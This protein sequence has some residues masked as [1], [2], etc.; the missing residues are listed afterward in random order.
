MKTITLAEL[1]QNLAVG[2]PDPNSE[3]FISEYSLKPWKFKDDK[4]L[5]EKRENAIFAPEFA[6]T[7]VGHF[8]KTLAGNP[9]GEMK[10]T[11]KRLTLS[12]MKFGDVLTVYFGIRI[13]SKGKMFRPMIPCPNCSTPKKPFKFRDNVDLSTTDVVVYETQKDLT[14]EFKFDESYDETL[15][16]G[17]NTVNA[18]FD[19][20]VVQPPKWNDIEK[21]TSEE[22][23]NSAILRE[24]LL[25]S[26]IKF[27]GEFDESETRAIL[28]KGILDE[29]TKKD[30]D[31]LEEFIGDVSPGPDMTIQTRCPRCKT[32]F[33]R[34]LDWS[35]DNF[36]S[37]S[38]KSGSGNKS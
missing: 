22:F 27:L 18:Q 30:I 20:V 5:A 32:S 21:L 12:Q 38:S 4:I 9:F 16:S 15:G 24:T 6:A 17:D 36:F 31:D 26:S 28:E 37:T 7:I 23:S 13:N 34:T 19:R 14:H 35:Y 29:L 3:G 11:E 10:D 25:K 2:F 33:S 1:G 8:A